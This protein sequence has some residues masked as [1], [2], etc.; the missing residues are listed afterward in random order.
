MKKTDIIGWIEL[1]ESMVTNIDARDIEARLTIILTTREGI[2]VS[3]ST[4]DVIN[5]IKQG[6]N[7]L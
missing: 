4:Q 1:L 3:F 7:S 2:E 6:V 5:I